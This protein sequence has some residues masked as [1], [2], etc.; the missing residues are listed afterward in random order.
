MTASLLPQNVLIYLDHAADCQI[1]LSARV[2]FGLTYSGTA[3]NRALIK[4]CNKEVFG[5]QVAVLDRR[6]IPCTRSSVLMF[7]CLFCIFIFAYTDDPSVWVVEPAGQDYVN[8][9]LKEFSRV[10]S[11]GS[12]GGLRGLKRSWILSS[13]IDIN[14]NRIYWLQI[15]PQPPVSAR[16]S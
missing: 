11:W 3:G 13:L 6:T 14:S 8:D 12:V 2:M 7:M 4:T 16:S 5:R 1:Y 9:V 10:R 15:R